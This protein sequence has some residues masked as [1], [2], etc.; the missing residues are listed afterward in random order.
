MYT[1]SVYGGLISVL[2]SKSIEQLC[3]MKIGMFS[4]G[5]GSAATM[6]AIKVTDNIDDLQKLKS[7]FASL[8]KD[9]VNKRIKVHPEYFNRLVSD[10]ENNH[11]R[12]PPLKPEF[13]IESFWPATYYLVEIDG[14]YRRTYKLKIADDYKANGNSNG[15]GNGYYHQNGHCIVNGKY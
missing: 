12:K 8:P 4:Y 5:S 11:K 10:L 3:G 2:I 1:A 15:N 6:F 7:H 9:L 14:L 13:P